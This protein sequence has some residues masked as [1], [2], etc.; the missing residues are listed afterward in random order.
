MDSGNIVADGTL[1]NSLKS[2]AARPAS[3]SA[4]PIRREKI[5]AWKL[6]GLLGGNTG[7]CARHGRANN[8]S[9]RC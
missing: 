9:G 5:T 2:P 8:L 6:Q 1:L 7:K 4:S 3:F